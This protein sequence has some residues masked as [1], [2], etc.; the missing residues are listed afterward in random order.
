[1]LRLSGKNAKPETIQ[2]LRERLNGFEPRDL[3]ILDEDTED[4]L[5]GMIS[6]LL[7]DSKR[8]CTSFKIKEK[9]NSALKKL[10]EEF[11]DLVV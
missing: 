11:P 3:V 1:M 7:G 9:F 2:T 4:I 5:P 6:I 10:A 8:S